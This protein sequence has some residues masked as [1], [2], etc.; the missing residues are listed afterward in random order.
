MSR[1]LTELPFRKHPG[2]N[3]VLFAV[4]LLFGSLIVWPP[5][6]WVGRPVVCASAGTD[7]PCPGLVV[8]AVELTR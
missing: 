3:G 2:L 4:G 8:Q 1:R 7:W 6:F 5:L